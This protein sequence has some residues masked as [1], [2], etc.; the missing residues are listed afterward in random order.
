MAETIL[1]EI[2]YVVGFGAIALAV[3]FWKEAWA[4][5]H[6]S[7]HWIQQRAPMALVLSIPN[8]VVGIACLV[9]IQML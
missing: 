4:C 9:V 6:S 2:G 5:Y 1:R 8:L 3:W 7:E